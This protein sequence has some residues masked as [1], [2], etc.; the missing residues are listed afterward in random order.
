MR[1]ILAGLVLGVDSVVAH[2]G[3]A[4]VSTFGQRARLFAVSAALFAFGFAWLLSGPGFVP[5]IN[6]DNGAYVSS[7]ATG[8]LNWSSYPWNNHLG[9]LQEYLL[10][11]WLARGLGMTLID[12]FRI[13]GA[14][15]FTIAFVA[16]ADTL[17]VL[18]RSVLLAA[19]LSVV[20]ATAWVNLHYHLI[21]EDNWLF[22][23]PAAVLLRIC[24]LRADRWRWWDG[25][26]AGALLT[27]AF[28]GSWQAL[29]Y[30]APPLGAALLAGPR[31]RSW[32][33]S[34]RDAL[35]VPTAFFLSLMGW[36]ALSVLTSSMKWAR[37]WAVILS[38]P[39]PSFLP[40]TARQLWAFVASGLPLDTIGTAVQYHLTF[41]AYR[42]S[43]TLPLSTK[44]LGGLALGIEVAL[45]IGGTWWALRRKD[46]RFHLLPAMLLLF[47]L[48]T[49]LHKDDATYAEL[50]RFDFVPPFLVLIAGVCL[51]AAAPKAR[52]RAGIATLLVAGILIQTVLGL[53]WA[54]HERASYRTTLPWAELHKP[55]TQVYGR[56]GLGWFGYF[57][58]LRHENPHV[59]RFVFVV[60]EFSSGWWNFDLVG[61][62][63]SELPDHLTI[64]VEPVALDRP[65]S[66]WRFPIKYMSLLEARRRG[67][68]AG[69]AWL[70]QDARALA[71][72]VAP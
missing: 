18:T 39:D 25:L 48:A 42:L 22:L 43:W 65:L 11:T 13:V 14:T 62:L 70:S 35:V 32:A 24:V 23:A 26:T 10:G 8:A 17:R 57:R 37:L 21:I 20:W 6:W 56:D 60:S 58:R 16:L 52:V 29:P 36:A 40:K 59:C 33:T 49:S 19:L 38:R 7:L 66:I 45:F 15:A 2:G 28:L 12:G 67:L 4:I 30:L 61:A 69:C 64:G 63:W 9:I 46:L 3:R 31:E 71:D 41:S 53:R 50:K 44:S 27:L 55:P 54:A 1:K 72:K 5:L 34:V 47:T 51:G 68:L